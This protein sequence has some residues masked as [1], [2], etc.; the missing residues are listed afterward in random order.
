MVIMINVIQQKYQWISNYLSWYCNWS[1]KSKYW[2]DSYLSFGKVNTFL[3]HKILM[4]NFPV[5]S[6]IQDKKNLVRG[7]ICFY[8]VELNLLPVSQETV[9]GKCGPKT[10]ASISQMCSA[11]S[12]FWSWY[13]AYF[14]ICLGSSLQVTPIVTFDLDW[15]VLSYRCFWFQK[16]NFH[17]FYTV[18][19]C[20]WCIYN[21]YL[22]YN[23][24][25]LIKMKCILTSF[26]YSK[27]Q[28]HVTTHKPDIFEALEFNH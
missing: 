3:S 1:V 26:I 12:S 5:L 2:M 17:S 7:Q 8:F 24:L 27:P 21:T 10:G 22:F 19:I 6:K 4:D 15:M 20:T 9:S 11:T 18:Q 25:L 16:K 13:F 14:D 23:L 28:Q